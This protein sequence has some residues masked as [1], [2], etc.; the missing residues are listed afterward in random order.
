MHLQRMFPKGTKSD[1]IG[2]KE[3]KGKSMIDMYIRASI[4]S[5]NISVAGM[6][7]KETPS[8]L[9][10]LNITVH[11]MANTEARVEFRIHLITEGLV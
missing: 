8:N 7:S 4:G 9:I 6:E 11:P 10:M 5:T 3:P 1:P 2:R